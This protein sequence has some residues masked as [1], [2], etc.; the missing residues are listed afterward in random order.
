MAGISFKPWS[1]EIVS[2]EIVFDKDEDWGTGGD[3]SD[4][5]I[6]NVA[7]HEVGHVVGLGHVSAPKDGLLTMYRYTRQGVT[8]KQTLGLADK[9]GYEYRDE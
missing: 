4:F 3:T 7:A 5:D 2:F 9:L 8:I 1:K 6:Q